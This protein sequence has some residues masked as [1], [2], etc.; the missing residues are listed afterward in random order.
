MIPT[1]TL[2]V[3]LGAVLVGVGIDVVAGA[4]TPGYG[5]GL[6]AVGVIV[7]TAGSALVARV[8]RDDDADPHPDASEPG[9]EGERRGG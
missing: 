7:L 6:G 9:G 3:L 8:L 1:R 4:Q 5:A 2:A